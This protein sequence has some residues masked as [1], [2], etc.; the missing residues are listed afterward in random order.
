MIPTTS[1]LAICHDRINLVTFA[2]IQ[3]SFVVCSND[4][5]V[6]RLGLLDLLR[7]SNNHRLSAYVKEWLPGQA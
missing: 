2:Y 1:Y 6:D 5:L 3:D 4:N 7:C